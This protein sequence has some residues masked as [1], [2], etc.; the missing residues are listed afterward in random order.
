MRTADDDFFIVG[1]F[2]FDAANCLAY[3]S[4]L[5][6]NARIVQ[7]ADSRGLREAI[8]L[9]DRDA[10]H[11]EKLLR[12]GRKRSR[13]TDERAKMRAETLFDLAENKFASERQPKRVECASATGILA[14]P[15][16]AGLRKKRADW[17]G[18]LGESILDAAA[19]TLEERRHVQKIVRGGEANLVG[20]FRE[21]GGKGQNALAR[22]AGQQ[23]NPRGGEIKGRVMEDAIGLAVLA[24]EL[25]EALCG[26]GKHVGQ[27][28]GAEASTLRF[29]RSAGGVDDGDEVSIRAR[30]GSVRNRLSEHGLLL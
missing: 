9:Q 18:P 8:C 1:D 17:S 27:V 29:A 20:E 28:A 16:F 5:D 7:R 11:Q 4:R 19:Y 14:L 2:H 26:A 24:H 30:I 12:F 25:V 15:C 10:E 3:V 21:I 23:E 6:R 13:A 22:Q